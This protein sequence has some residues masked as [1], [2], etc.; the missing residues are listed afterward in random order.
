MVLIVTSAETSLIRIKEIQIK[1]VEVA[2][3]LRDASAVAQVAICL[4]VISPLIWIHVQV[5]LSKSHFI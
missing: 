5:F 3:S 4:I 2:G 1:S